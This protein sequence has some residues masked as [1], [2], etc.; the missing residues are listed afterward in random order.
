MELRG[1]A[2]LLRALRKAAKDYPGALAR[3]LYAEGFDIQS[4]AMRICPVDVTVLVSSAYTSPP[5]GPDAVVEVGFGT[6][7]AVYQHEKTELRHK[8]GKQAKYLE[9]P[10]NER[11]GVLL[12]NLM[13]RTRANILSGQ[14]SEA[15]APLGA[16]RPMV[17]T[18]RRPK[19]AMRPRKGSRRP[20][21]R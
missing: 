10:V 8:P 15:I 13:S 21:R 16:T 5:T 6:H 12:G 19:R 2:A 4:A 11:S 20:R 14:T 18:G 17:V 9:T 7:Y 1:D 3:A